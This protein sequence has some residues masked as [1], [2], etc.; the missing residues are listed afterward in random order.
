MQTTIADI[1]AQTSGASPEE[2]QM[3]LVLQGSQGKTL[4]V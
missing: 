4:S 1:R 2:T 3:D